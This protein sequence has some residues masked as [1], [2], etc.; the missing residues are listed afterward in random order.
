MLFLIAVEFALALND[1]DIYAWFSRMFLSNL[2]VPIY[3]KQ[4]EVNVS[5]L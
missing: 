2:S 4:L 5:I 1:E 3:V